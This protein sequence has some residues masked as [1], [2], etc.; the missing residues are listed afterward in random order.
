[1][2]YLD[3]GDLISVVKAL[4]SMRVEREEGTEWLVITRN[5]QIPR[6]HPAR[7]YHQL[8]FRAEDGCVPSFMGAHGR[9]SVT[10]SNVL[11]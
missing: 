8:R 9:Y 6:L 1:M 4:N 10:E 7:T 5:V 3:C 11:L 2:A